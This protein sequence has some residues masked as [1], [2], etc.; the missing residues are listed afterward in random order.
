MVGGQSAG[1]VADQA[2]AA[3]C[4]FGFAADGTE[5]GGH[6]REGPPG[7][8]EEGA[9]REQAAQHGEHHLQAVHLVS[10]GRSIIDPERTA[11][12]WPNS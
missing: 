1:T 4:L 12:R 11:R 9:G 8:G 5:G 7:A 6:G 10:A 2:R 3:G